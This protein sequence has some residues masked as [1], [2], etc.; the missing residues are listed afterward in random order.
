MHTSPRSLHSTPSQPP[1]AH[2]TV[3]QQLP[4]PQRRQCHELLTQLLAQVIH[5]ESIQ[6][7]SHE[8]QD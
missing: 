3:W 6:E 2:P 4:D 7:R 5:G 8:H 1:C